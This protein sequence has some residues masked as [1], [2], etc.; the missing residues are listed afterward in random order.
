MF[1]DLEEKG[2]TWD[3][4]DPRQLH[5]AKPALELGSEVEEWEGQTERAEAKRSGQESTRET[6]DQQAGGSEC[7]L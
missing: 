6:W 5:G 4:D 3:Q 1:W 2:V 7:V